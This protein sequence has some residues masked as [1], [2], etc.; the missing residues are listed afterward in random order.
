MENQINPGNQNTQQI[1][2]TPMSQPTVT[3]E[4]P[5]IRFLLIGGM[6]FICFIVFGFGGYYLGKQSSIPREEIVEARNQA[7]LNSI[8][9]TNNPRISENKIT[10]PVD[11]CTTSF[12]SKYLKMSFK[13][14]SCVWKLSEK[15]I[16]PEA[17]VYSTITAKHN[18]NHQIV[19]NANT[20]GM[21][22]GYP[23]CGDVN[24]IILLDNDIVR[25]HMGKNLPGESPK[26]YHYLNSK[27][28]YAIKGYS[29]K[30]GDEEFNEYFTF[31]SPEAFPNTNMCWRADGINPVVVL[32]P[33]AGE[34]ESYKVNKDI[35]VSI[36]EENVS[37]K[38]FLKAADSL[39]VSVYLGISQ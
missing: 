17:G 7:P 29:G 25:I 18:P 28:D 13:Y 22:G 14:D 2:Q 4:K 19:I 3:P 9:A 33:K 20:V 5:K 16:T 35:T 38:E 36:E 11:G 31:L 39:A 34:T 30:H 10:Q 24:D 1:G 8:P 32:Q 21:G 12:S 6:V 15:L 23:V 27:N 37:D 26:Y